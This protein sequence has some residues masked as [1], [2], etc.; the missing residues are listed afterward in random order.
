ML[1]L[2]GVKPGTNESIIPMDV[3]QMAATGI[4]VLSGISWVPGIYF[5]LPWFIWL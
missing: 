4:T 1:L 5:L 3:V 2:D